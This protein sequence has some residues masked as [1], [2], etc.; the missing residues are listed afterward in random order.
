[1]LSN[2]SF[3]LG[4]WVTSAI[5]HSAAKS[6]GYLFFLPKVSIA[7]V[8]K[9]DCMTLLLFFPIAEYNSASSC[10]FESLVL[11]GRYYDF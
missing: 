7:L 4:S 1:M 11:L 6:N 9:H 10:S 8:P 2:A 5:K 3:Y